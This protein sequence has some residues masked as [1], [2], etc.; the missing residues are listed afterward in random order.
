MPGRAH[1]DD[2]GGRNR[3]D[4][5]TRRLSLPRPDRHREDRDR[6]GARR[7]PVRLGRAPDQARHERVP[8][9]GVVRAPAVGLDGRATRSRAHFCRSKGSV[10]GDPPR[11]VREGVGAGVGPLPPGVRRRSDDRPAGKG[12]RLPPQR[13]RAHLERGL[14]DRA[15]AG[16]R[17]RPAGGALQPRGRRARAADIVPTGVSEPA[18]PRRRVP[19]FERSAM[20]SAGEGAGGRA[21]PARVARPAVGGRDRRLGVRLPDRGRVQPAARGAAAQTRGRTSC[22]RAA[23]SGD[24]RAIHPRR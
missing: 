10:R 20:R 8:D 9:G 21:R 14:G 22:P 23:G 5:A 17:L 4:A 2:Q 7:V 13:D 19:P 12:R 3:P 1:R 16:P 18:R 6:Q 15:R 11:R 24:R